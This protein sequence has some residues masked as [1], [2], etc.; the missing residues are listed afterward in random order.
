MSACLEQAESYKQSTVQ[1]V[2][3]KK[4]FIVA[5]FFT[6]CVY[7]VCLIGKHILKECKQNDKLRPYHE[8]FERLQDDIVGKS[9]FF[10][11]LLMI[12]SQINPTVFGALIVYGYLGALGLQF[13]GAVF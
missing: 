2:Q 13:V 11:Y 7:T 8:K 4:S 6:Y 12:V 9:F 5:F 10:F 1:V 3:T